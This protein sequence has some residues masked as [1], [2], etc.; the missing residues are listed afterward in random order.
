MTIAFDIT[1]CTALNYIWRSHNRQHAHKIKKTMLLSVQDIR[2]CFWRP[3]L[4][5]ILLQLRVSRW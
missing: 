2:L 5:L 3:L 4:Q 1:L